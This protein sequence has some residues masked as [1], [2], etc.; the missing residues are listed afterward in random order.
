MLLTILLVVLCI[1][2]LIYLAPISIGENMVAA[3]VV[4]ALWAFAEAISFL[5][6]AGLFWLICWAFSL[7]FTW[8]VAFGIWL[9]WT[10][11]YTLI[12]PKN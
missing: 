5:V 4:F 7:T 9:I 3:L 11:I 8:K 12:K 6:I 2:L 10:L 1:G